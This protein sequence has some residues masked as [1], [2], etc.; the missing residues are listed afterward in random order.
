MS[1]A[2]IWLQQKPFCERVRMAF[3]NGSIAFMANSALPC[4]SF[5]T[6]SH[7]S[8]TRPSGQERIRVRQLSAAF[9]DSRKAR[10]RNTAFFTHWH[11]SCLMRGIFIMTRES[12]VR[13]K[14]IRP[15]SA[16]FQEDARLFPCRL[17]SGADLRRSSLRTKCAAGQNA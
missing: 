16:L 10:R 15:P 8:R 5:A 17:P 6:D 7:P 1:S 9:P 2:R 3:S 14:N 12:H 11:D 4:I 13:Q